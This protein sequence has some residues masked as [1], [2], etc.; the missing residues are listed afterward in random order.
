MTRIP[1]KPVKALWTGLALSL[2]APS[3]AQ[4]PASPRIVMQSGVAVTQTNAGKVQ[5]LVRNGIQTFR[6]I[7]YA[8]ATRFDSAV[9]S[10]PWHDTRLAISYG[11]I[12]RQPIDPVFREPQAFVSD[13]KFWP[14]SENCLNLNVWTPKLDGKKRPVMVWLHGGGF[15]SGSSIE[16]PYY[17]GENLSRRGDVVVVSVNHRLNALGFMDLSGYG[18]QYRGSANAG[19]SD[20]VTGLQWVRDNAAAFGGD[21]D[22][23]TIFGQSGGG[24]KVVTL[25]AAP[26]AK[27]LFHKAIVMS[28]VMGPPQARAIDQQTA[29]RVAALTFKHAGLR[30]GDVDGLRALPYDQ[31]SAAG[32]KALEEAGRVAGQGGPMLPGFPRIMWGPVHDRTFLPDRPFDGTAPAVSASIPLL[33]GSTLSEFQLINPALRGR[34]GWTDARAIEFARKNYGARAD[35]V[36]ATFRK[37]YPGLPLWEVGAIDPAGR[38]GALAVAAMKAAQPAPVYNYLFAWRSPVMDYAWSAGHTGDI[39]FYFDNAALGVQATGG[40][41]QVDRLT[42]A[43]SDAWIAFARTGNPGTRALPKWP[44]F[45]AA[46][47]ATMI[48]DTRSR[49]A[50]GH[51]AA[52]LDLLA[53]SPR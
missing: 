40:G 8:T 38:N 24:G 29:R 25:L 15:F 45:S 51:D 30:D 37:A 11:N 26:S 44:V 35:A 49:V 12:C 10:K 1:T 43:I 46:K 53:G 7:P 47:P 52:L 31:L 9:R 42:G 34:A 6:G 48:L 4:S 23:V 14:A 16:L 17:D 33:I 20:I 27:G 21:P 41:P 3:V 39:A 50:I 36:M 13:W 2:T 18:N 5:G 32:N 22:N 28:G 19:M